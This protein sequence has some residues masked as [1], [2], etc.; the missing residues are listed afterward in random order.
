MKYLVA[1]ITLCLCCSFADAGIR[2]RVENRQ[3]KQQRYI[4]VNKCGECQPQTQPQFRYLTPQSSYSQQFQ[5]LP[6]QGCSNGSC[7]PLQYSP[8][9]PIFNPR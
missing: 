3:Q 6:M 2:Y 8:Q 9:R 4:V 7:Q 1:L 5:Y